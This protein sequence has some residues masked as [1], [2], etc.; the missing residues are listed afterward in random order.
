MY[1]SNC[2]YK[3][4]DGY[5][6]C[7][8]CGTKLIDPSKLE[9]N[10]NFPENTSGRIYTEKRLHSK[11]KQSENRQPKLSMFRRKKK[12]ILI[13][14][15]LLIIGCAVAGLWRHYGSNAE[16]DI[17][18]V[19]KD[20]SEYLVK[21][22][23]KNYTFELN[24]T[25]GADLPE[26][27]KV[28]GQVVDVKCIEK[29]GIVKIKAP[30]GGYEEGEIYTVD[31]S[32][33]GSF[34]NAGLENAK[35]LTFIIKHKNE[36]EVTYKEGVHDLGNKA[37]E[38]LGDTVKLNGGEYKNGEIILADSDGDKIQ[39]IYK[40]QNVSSDNGK[41]TATF[42]EPKADEVYD[43]IDV[44]FYDNLDMNNIVVDE[45]DLIGCLGDSGILEAAFGT[46]Y[47]KDKK[48]K[49]KLSVDVDVSG[50]ELKCKVEV[51]IEDR[52]NPD[53]KL[54]IT[55]E[56]SAKTLYKNKNNQ[57]MLSSTF[58]AEADTTFRIEGKKSADV[59]AKILG[60]IEKLTSMEG[61]LNSPNQFEV[62]VIPVK[63]PVYGP[64]YI[65]WEIGLKGDVSMKGSFEIGIKA[66]AA[67]T[68]GAVYD[69]NTNKVIKKFGEFDAALNGDFAVN[70][71]VEAFTGF[72]LDVAGVV[73]LLIDIGFEG[74]IGP[75]ADAKG[76]L[77]IENIPN[78]PT[79]D[80]YYDVETGVKLKGKVVIE[81]VRSKDIEIP[82][83][84]KKWKTFKKSNR[85]RLN[86]VDLEDS[87]E[88]SGG[89]FYIDNLYAEYYDV[90]TS[91]T[92]E[93]IIK[94]YEL[95]IDGQRTSV[96]EGI[97]YTDIAPGTYKFVLKWE[98]GK[99][100]YKFE[101]DV[102]LT[103]FDPNTAFEGT[104]WY[105]YH[106]Q[107][108]GS[109]SYIILNGNG[110]FDEYNL[111]SSQYMPDNGLWEYRN[112]NIYLTYAETGEVEYI[113]NGDRDHYRSAKKQKM[114]VGNE[115]C[116][117]S[118]DETGNDIIWNITN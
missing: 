88:V 6:Y 117:L 65:R 97:A 104:S 93:K 57:V 7:A 28:S 74:Q 85:I 73:P 21:Q 102:K 76:C 63:I 49:D 47:A 8:K 72:Y 23:P 59:K 2:G 53:L 15:A 94:D 44:F 52:A 64:I 83:L 32:E 81:L 17:E 29:D 67:I 38:V 113:Q 35:V 4:D 91:S 90:L 41:V 5:V 114:M 106:G 13:L 99:I 79:L 115:Y 77:V 45:E 10:K 95:Y 12:Q 105:W 96:D 68:A 107:S 51:T 3:N 116:T 43:N 25:E 84:D 1:C 9:T 55:S 58:K 42:T 86:S 14:I 46:V 30:E 39:E 54:I 110:R 62:P 100:E 31:V 92:D 16:L 108:L 71:G 69:G 70:G 40:L 112:G 66:K 101:K 98:L 103:E 75:Y 11:S 33:I 82:V 80:G 19:D 22:L 61:N 109:Q 78:N 18:L 20:C 50:D 48:A 60:D 36:A 34:T 26:I 87:Y 89:Q 118:R 27:Q 111:G 56:I 24:R 37:I